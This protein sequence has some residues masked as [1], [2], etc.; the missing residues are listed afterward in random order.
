MGDN[1]LMAGMVTKMLHADLLILLTTAGGVREFRPGGASRRVPLIEA[2][3][4]RIFKLVAPQHGDISTGGMGSKPLSPGCCSARPSALICD[5]MRPL[6]RMG[7]GH[8]D[9]AQCA[10]CGR[11]CTAGKR[12]K[13]SSCQLNHCSMVSAMLTMMKAAT[14]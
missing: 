7:P 2:V 5:T 4:P 14:S 1:D 13:M 3:T 11:C 9:A 12:E 10:G 6:G 8:S